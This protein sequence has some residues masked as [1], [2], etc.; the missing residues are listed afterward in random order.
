MPSI[1]LIR[2]AQS[3][4]NA[5]G[6]QSRDV[7]ITPAGQEMAKSICGSYDLII[8]SPLRR[9]RE[10]LA[11]SQI[12]C[13]KIIFSHLCRE[14]RDGNAIN[15]LSDE[16]DDMLHE[17]EE[18]LSNRIAELKKLVYELHPEYPKIGI[19]CHACFVHRLGGG[20]LANCGSLSM[21]I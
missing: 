13:G 9:T 16:P 21:T 2:H 10:T 19:V 17:T 3:T 8:C 15:L 1:I 11:A 14:V 7:P 6:D 5:W 12:Q 20:H 4:Y 18:E